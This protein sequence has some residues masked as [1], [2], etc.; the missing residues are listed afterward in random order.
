MLN[1]TNIYNIKYLYQTKNYSIREI[2]KELNVSRQTIKKIIDSNFEQSNYN[3]DKSTNLFVD[4]FYQK[5][6]QLVNENK[7]SYA[8]LTNKRIYSI[9]KPIGYNGSYDTLNNFINQ[10]KANNKVNK[11][12]IPLEFQPGEAAQFDWGYEKILLNGNEVNV[13]AARI[14]L[15]YSRFSF[16]I[17]YPNEKIEM[18][19]DSHGEA[20]KFFEGIPQRII[21]DNMKTIV[22][23][24]LSGKD[25]IIN[26][27][28]IEMACHYLFEYTLCTPASGWE[29]GR[30][31][32]KIQTTRESFFI[33]LIRAKSFADANNQLVNMAVEYAKNTKH[34]EFK[35]KSIYE[36]FLE[37]KPYLKKFTFKYNS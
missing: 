22:S 9:I 33:P 15:C 17:I 18:L 4:G 31:E 2:A 7:N 5:V 34:V 25:R 13:K 11:A 10:Y 26:D 12:Y 24:V 6:I 32:R 3:R 29:K 16:I 35:N 36:V 27:K 30:V 28:Y 37:E 20:F 8:K 1:M 21:Y 19:L 23:K 14:T